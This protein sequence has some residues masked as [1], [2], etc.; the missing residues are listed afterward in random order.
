MSKTA[1]WSKLKNMKAHDSDIDFKHIGLH[2]FFDTNDD[3]DTDWEDQFGLNLQPDGGS[4]VQA[5][6]I[7]QK[8]SADGYLHIKIPH[9]FTARF[10]EMIILP[11][12][13]SKIDQV[14]ANVNEPEPEWDTD[15]EAAESSLGLTMHTFDMLE[16]ECGPEDLSKWK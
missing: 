2:A 1:V 9:D 13:D 16:Q 10:V 6:K 15:Y 8:V 4:I 11:I 5:L 12:S 3:L 14:V 7:T